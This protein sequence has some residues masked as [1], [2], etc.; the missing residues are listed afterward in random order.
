MLFVIFMI[1]DVDIFVFVYGF[2]LKN[3]IKIGLLLNGD[4]ELG[5]YYMDMKGI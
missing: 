4:F 2:L 3:K 1:I 5:L